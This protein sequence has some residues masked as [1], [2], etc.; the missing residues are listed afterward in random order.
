LT[1]AAVYALGLLCP[2]VPSFVWSMLIKAIIAGN[3]TPQHIL[4]FMASHGVKSYPQD[5]YPLDPP[6]A[7][8]PNNLGAQ[9]G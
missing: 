3:I 2:A 1:P 4:D 8:T 9:N 7:S 5:G 6:K